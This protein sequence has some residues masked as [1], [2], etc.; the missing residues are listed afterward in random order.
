[1]KKVLIVEGMSCGHCKAAVEKA[2]KAI[3]G[4]QNAVVDL[5]K[6]SAEV[7]LAKEVSNEILTNAVVDAGY[8]VVEVK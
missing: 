6:K 3:D 4:V 5:D 2:L 1:M 7:E 8:E